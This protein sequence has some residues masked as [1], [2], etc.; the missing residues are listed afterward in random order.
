MKI[1]SGQ[2]IKRLN[3]RPVMTDQ[4]ILTDVDGQMVIINGQ[5]QMTGGRELTVGDVISTILT[6]RKIDQF[7]PLKA[8]ALAQRFYMIDTTEL[9]ESDFNSLRDMV[10][11]NDQYIPLVRAQV[12]QVLIEAKDGGEKVNR[13]S[14]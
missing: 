1:N 5:P 7:N 12:L 14:P 13:S 2:V 6:T 8:Y 3:G 4:E 9:D 10:E 11:K